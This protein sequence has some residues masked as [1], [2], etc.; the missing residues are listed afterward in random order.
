MALWEVTRE[1]NKQ[2]GEPEWIFPLLVCFSV[3][4]KKQNKNTEASLQ[5]Q[6]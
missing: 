3:I 5:T 4:E 1:E 6:N 2:T